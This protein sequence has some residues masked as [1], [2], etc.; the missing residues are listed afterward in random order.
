MISRPSETCF[1]CRY[2][3]LFLCNEGNSIALQ[4]FLFRL[5]FFSAAKEQTFNKTIN[6]NNK[7]FSSLFY[8]CVFHCFEFLCVL[9][10]F[11]FVGGVRAHNRYE[12][13]LEDY[14]EAVARVDK[15]KEEQLRQQQSFG[16]RGLET[17][18]S[19]IETASNVW[20]KV[21]SESSRSHKASAPNE[22]STMTE[23]MLFDRQT[24]NDFAT[25]ING[26]C[27]IHVYKCA[28]AKHKKDKSDRENK[29][30]NTSIAI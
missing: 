15:L 24:T 12:Q 22:Q 9:L 17:A 21:S 27:V 6:E 29:D 5:C 16:W 10:Y 28:S 1:F 25:D 7:Y 4:L 30:E 14:E 13:G 2:R 23:T 11:L 3:Y 26:M 8:T 20:N 19:F 18:L